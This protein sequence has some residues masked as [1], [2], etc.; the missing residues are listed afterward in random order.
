MNQKIDFPNL[1][2][3]YISLND[4]RKKADETRLQCDVNQIPVDPNLIAEKFGFNIVPTANL[5]D[6]TSIEAF[7]VYNKKEI[8]IDLERF[9]NENYWF[10][11]KFSIAHELGHY[12]LHSDIY[13]NIKFEDYEYTD[14][15]SFQ[16]TIPENKILWI[17]RHADEFAGRLLVPYDILVEEVKAIYPKIDKEHPK[18]E[19]DPI[20]IISSLLHHKF[21]VSKEVMRIRIQKEKIEI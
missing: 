5:L 13:E 14:W 20:D 3:P 18:S 1:T 15:I 2:S 4:I 7:L 6:K 10:R 8:L 19:F 16:K 21:E 11:S 17:E 12:F 9:Q